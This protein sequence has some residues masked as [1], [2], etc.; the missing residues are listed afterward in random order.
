QD[1]LSG[2]AISKIVSKTNQQGSLCNADLS[3]S[4]PSSPSFGDRADDET[5]VVLQARITTFSGSSTKAGFFRSAAVLGV[6]AAEA[7]QHAHEQG[8]FHRDIKPGNLMLDANT[9]PYLTDFGLARIEADAGITRTGDLVGTLRYMSPEQALAKR[10][11]SD[12]R[13]DIYSLGVTLYELIGLR[14]LFDS[15]DRQELLQKIAFQDPVKLRRIEPLIPV[16]LETIVHKAIEK[17][18]DDRYLS[19]AELAADLQAF[20]DD[21]TIQA[22]P[23]TVS[24]KLIKWSRRHKPMVWTMAMSGAA[25]V[26]MAISALA[27]SNL[28]IAQ[29]RQASEQKAA[30]AN[31][32]IRF[33]TEDLLGAASPLNEPDR[34]IRLRTVVDRAA[35]R[36]DDQLADQPLVAAEIRGTLG[37]TYHAL[38]EYTLGE[39][40]FREALK[41]YT[42]LLGEEHRDTQE[43]QRKLALV[44][45]DQG[46]DAEAEKLIRSVFDARMAELGDQHLDTLESMSDVGELSFFCGQHVTARRLFGHVV[47]ARLKQLGAEHPLTLDAQHRFAEATSQLDYRRDNVQEAESL[48]RQVLSQREKV[49]SQEHPHALETRF[50]LASL[51]LKQS[52]LDEAE[53]EF[54]KL[55]DIATETLGA[56]HT[57]TLHCKTSLASTFTQQRQFD[58][59]HQLNTLALQ[60]AKKVLG[61]EHPLTLQIQLGLAANYAAQRENEQATQLYE[62]SLTSLRQMLGEHHPMTHYAKCKLLACYEA[63]GL[64]GKV[65]ELREVIDSPEDLAGSM[66]ASWFWGD[67]LSFRAR[68]SLRQAE[69][70]AELKALG[71]YQVPSVLNGFEATVLNGTRVIS[72]KFGPALAFDGEDDRADI[73]DHPELAFT[74]SMTIHCWLRIDSFPEPETEHGTI[75]M[76]SDNRNGRDPYFLTTLPSGEIAF[77][78]TSLD[79]GASI[80]AKA[81]EKEFIHVAASLD[82]SSGFMRLYINGQPVSQIQTEVRPFADLMQGRDPGVGVGNHFGIRIHAYNFPFHGVIEQLTITDTA[83]SAEEIQRLAKEGFER[84]P[85]DLQDN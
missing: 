23:P 54:R 11:V 14:P 31:A 8:V 16:E 40:H 32:V 24:D 64:D 60:E 37:E 81:P 70:W 29:E 30:T 77:G 59:S 49:L 75:V 42:T 3:P 53:S 15:K 36:I 80:S 83:L 27:V 55:Q 58:A 5:E 45:L 44:L 84:R 62:Q 52:K 78:V 7:L 28:V 1:A 22:K 33:I 6:Q 74:E 47:E 61:E 4:L 68:Q 21:R 56:T 34:D 76:R 18:P 39:Q 41:T 25:M 43:C 63:Q 10:A 12:G 46:H 50:F 73:E 72:G 38:G 2:D 66:S 65:S 13:S 79:A 69:H 57:F 26:T 17:S 67:P 20:L 71:S 82:D 51:L 19:A 85:A 35:A 48:F 9:K